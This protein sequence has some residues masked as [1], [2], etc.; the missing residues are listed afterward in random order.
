ML[1]TIL[2]AIII[3][4]VVFWLLELFLSCWKILYP[5]TDCRGR[6]DTT[7]QPLF[8]IASCILKFT[9]KPFRTVSTDL[10]NGNSQGGSL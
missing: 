1:H 2:W 3:L 4:L 7:R 5:Y 10:G 9:P 8:T 6:S